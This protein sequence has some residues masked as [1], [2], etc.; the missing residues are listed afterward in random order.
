M[1]DISALSQKSK[2]GTVGIGLT[3]GH[4]GSV[5]WYTGNLI[6]FNKN[7]NRLYGTNIKKYMHMGYNEVRS[8]EL[9]LSDYAKKYKF[10]FGKVG[11]D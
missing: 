10:E 11:G 1:S 7:D 3:V 2:E 6:K 9:A 8:Q 5:Y 4:D